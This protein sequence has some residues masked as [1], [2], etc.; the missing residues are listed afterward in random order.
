[1]L[2]SQAT[3]NKDVEVAN[4]PADGISCLKFSPVANHLVATSWDNQVRCWEINAATGASVPKAAIT[5]DA[6]VLSASWHSDGSKVFTGGCDKLVKMWD[7]P[8]N[9][10][11]QVAVHD[12]PIRHV[13]WLPSAN[14]LVTASWDKSIRYWDTRSPTPALSVALPE[15]C[16]AADATGALLLVGTADRNVLVYDI[17]NPQ[18]EFKMVQSLLKF[19][20]RCIACF[21]SQ[22][23]WAIGSIEGRVAIQHIND[24]EKDNNFSFKCHRKSNG[25]EIYAVNN[26]SF[27]PTYHTLATAGADGT[28]CFWDKKDKQRLKNFER[29]QVPISA[30]AFNADATIY[31]YAQSYDWSK[32]HEFYNP[33]IMKSQI[34]LHAVDDA[35]IRPKPQQQA[36]RR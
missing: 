4:A 17:R 12:A 32:G 2:S 24:A 14:M 30:A 13:I 10:Q 31:A 20:T 1:M 9:Q 18:K 23:G 21:P 16:Y 28:F 6:P 15:R 34:F 5:H 3:V 26:V 36:T 33:A 29:K 7:L 22:T 11:M 19:Q 27:H 8:T 25:T 35:E